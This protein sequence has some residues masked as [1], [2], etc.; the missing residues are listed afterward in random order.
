[1]LLLTFARADAASLA[2]WSSTSE[3]GI[4]SRYEVVT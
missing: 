3:G 1:M 4:T 2:A